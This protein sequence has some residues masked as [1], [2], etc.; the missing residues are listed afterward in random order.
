MKLLY[1]CFRFDSRDTR[2][3]QS[4]YC[5][6]TYLVRRDSRDI[7]NRDGRDIQNRDGL[8]NLGVSVSGLRAPET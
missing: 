8:D 7:Q 5:W 4:R 6:Y 1:L 2:K 3:W